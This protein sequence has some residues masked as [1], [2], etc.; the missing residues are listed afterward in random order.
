V[1][2]PV[3]ELYIVRC[4]ASLRQF[5]VRLYVDVCVTANKISLCRVLLVVVDCVGVA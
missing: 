4:I 1:Q 2:L 3:F 5:V